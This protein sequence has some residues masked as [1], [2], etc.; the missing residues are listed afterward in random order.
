MNPLRLGPDYE[1]DILIEQD[2]DI[3]E[4]SLDHLEGIF[5][6]YIICIAVSLALFL[7]E[8]WRGRSAPTAQT[9]R[10]AQTFVHISLTFPFVIN[11]LPVYN[12][13]HV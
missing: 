8:L 3:E 4:L 9:A 1:D 11:S 13:P 10:T 6:M 12:E 7:S 5:I 2:R